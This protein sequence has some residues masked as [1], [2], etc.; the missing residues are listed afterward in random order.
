VNQAFGLEAFEHSV[1]FASVRVYSFGDF[2][3]SLDAVFG[4]E[5]VD[6]CFLFG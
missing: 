1:D 3:A 6:F 2:S 4:E 5:N